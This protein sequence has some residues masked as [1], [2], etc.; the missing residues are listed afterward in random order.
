MAV[1]VRDEGRG[2][3]ETG[4]RAGGEELDDSPAASTARS[5]RKAHVGAARGPAPH[6]PLDGNGH[7]VHRHAH[8]PRDDESREG[9]RNFEARGG[10]EHQM[11]AATASAT[12]KPTKATIIAIFSYVHLRGGGTSSARWRRKT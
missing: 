10:D 9:E 4:N 12:M 1:D 6:A 8:E 3:H 2:E 11:F 5:S 7:D